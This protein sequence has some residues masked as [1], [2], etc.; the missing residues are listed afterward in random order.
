MA[1]HLKEYYHC[2]QDMFGNNF[3]TLRFNPQLKSK[4]IIEQLINVSSG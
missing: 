1:L 3:E 2:L 4:F